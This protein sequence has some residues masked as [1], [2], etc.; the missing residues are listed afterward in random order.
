MSD[1][2]THVNCSGYARDYEQKILKNLLQLNLAQTN[3]SDD[4]IAF[5][6][7]SCPQLVGIDT[8]SCKHLTDV[9]IVALVTQCT[10]LRTLWIS[11]NSNYTDESLHAIASHGHKIGSLNLEYCPL[12]TADAV[13]RVFAECAA[14]RSL[15]LA[16]DDINTDWIL[17][18]ASHLPSALWCLALSGNITDATLEAVAVR[19][20]S[21]EQ[22]DMRTCS[23][24]TAK[25]MIAIVR[26]CPLLNTLVVPAEC[27]VVNSSMALIWPLFRPQLEI[28]RC[29]EVR[30]LRLIGLTL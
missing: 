5:I 2:I 11:R 4:A 10:H 21:L 14:L 28:Q 27:E 24:Y 3:V 16:K 23:G 25:G 18:V 19:C 1:K 22:L 8:S 6:R 17:G 29:D 15:F 7:V 20:P 26:G 30:D 9:S 13:K 12:L